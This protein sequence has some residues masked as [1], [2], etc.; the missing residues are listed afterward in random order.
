[1]LKKLIWFINHFHGMTAHKNIDILP[2]PIVKTAVLTM[3]GNLKKEGSEEAE[4]SCLEEEVLDGKFQIVIGHPESWGSTRGQKLLLE[5]KK[6]D[7]ILLVAVDEFHQGLS[8]HW[9]QFRPNMTKVIGRLRVFRASSAPCLAMSAT[10]TSA[11]VSAMI[12]NLGIRTDPVLLQASPTQ[13]N[14][15]LVKIKRPPN[16]NGA[17]GY[18]DKNGI[19]APGYLALL[20]RI[21]L[22]DFITC[23]KTGKSVKKGLIFCR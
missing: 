7:L 10:A 9:D 15:K 19:T 4:L 12:A 18:M 5:L 3:R 13:S 22:T 11:E 17:D 1:M 23:I 14:I 20:E 8:G 2:F 16:N 6:R 21:F